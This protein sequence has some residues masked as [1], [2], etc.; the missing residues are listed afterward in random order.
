M[1]RGSLRLARSIRHKTEHAKHTCGARPST[2]LS[3]FFDAEQPPQLRLGAHAGVPVGVASRHRLE[4]LGAAAARRSRVAAATADGECSCSC[5]VVAPTLGCWLL[6]QMPLLR[7]GR[8]LQ[9][10][11]RRRGRTLQPIVMLLLVLLIRLLLQL[12]LL[13]F[14]CDGS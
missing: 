6:L 2:A 5:S 12:R 7:R 13:L 3:H 1:T 9:R 10:R 11:R 8:L 14:L 4:K